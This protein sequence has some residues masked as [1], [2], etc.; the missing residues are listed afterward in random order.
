MPAKATAK[1]T[2]DE[3]QLFFDKNLE[4]LKTVISCAEKAAKIRK[5]G[6]ARQD[7]SAHQA[8]VFV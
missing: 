7:Q 5:I 3:I 4:T 6:G 2:G 8:E 1:V